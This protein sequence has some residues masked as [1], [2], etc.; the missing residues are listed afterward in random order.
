MDNSDLATTN[1]K[2]DILVNVFLV[3]VLIVIALLGALAV[4]YARLA[5]CNNDVDRLKNNVA[6]LILEQ[7]KTDVITRQCLAE[8]IQLEHDYKTLIE[9]LG[10]HVEE[11]FLKGV[12]PKTER[13]PKTIPKKEG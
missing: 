2:Y 6:N 5:E 9:G 8:K 10:I 12:E 3:T 11:Y 13:A 7:N 1:K 4:V